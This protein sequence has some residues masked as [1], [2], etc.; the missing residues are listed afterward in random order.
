MWKY[1]EFFFVKKNIVSEKSQIFKTMSN[2]GTLSLVARVIRELVIKVW[3]LQ[4]EHDEFLIDEKCHKEISKTHRNI[5]IIPRE[6]CTSYLPP[7]N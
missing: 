4:Q 5:L 1:I 3:Y 7:L 6:S 2:I